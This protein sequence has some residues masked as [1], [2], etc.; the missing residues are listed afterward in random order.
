MLRKRD[1]AT[2]PCT[3]ENAKKNMNSTSWNPSAEAKTLLS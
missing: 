3:A 2:P 1:E